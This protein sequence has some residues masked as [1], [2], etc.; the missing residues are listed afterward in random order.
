MKIVAEGQKRVQCQHI[1]M[2]RSLNEGVN[3]FKL[4]DPACIHIRT[5]ASK[6]QMDGN[7]S[8]KIDLDRE[9]I[10]HLFAVAFA[11]TSFEDVLEL[12]AKEKSHLYSRR[13]ASATTSPSGER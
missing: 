13:E 9:E 6:V 8:I 3:L 5:T 7:Y 10:A 1:L 4:G 12:L 2:E 11:G